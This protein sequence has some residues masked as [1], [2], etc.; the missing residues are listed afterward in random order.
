MHCPLCCSSVA[1]PARL[2]PLQV[3]GGH[4]PP[5]P[6]LVPLYRDIDARAAEAQVRAMPPEPALHT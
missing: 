1:A 4:V 3:L 2:P 6:E 5:P